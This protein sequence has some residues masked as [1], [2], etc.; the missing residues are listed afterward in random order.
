MRLL[1]AC[2]V[3][4][5]FAATA[6][7]AA[8]LTAT[9]RKSEVKLHAAPD[10]ESGVAEETEAGRHGRHRLAAGAL[11]RVE[12]PRR[13]ERLRAHQRCAG[14][15][16]QRRGQQRQH[17]RADQRQGGRG[18]RFRDRGG[19]RHRG[20]RAESGL[21]QPDAARHDGREPY[22]RHGRGRICRRARLAGDDRRLGRRGETE[23][24]RQEGVV[25]GSGRAA[26]PVRHDG[27]ARPEGELATRH[28]RQG[29]AEVRIRTGGGGNR[30]GP[31]DRRTR[32]WR[33][34]AVE[35][36]RGAEARQCGRPLGRLADQPPRTALDL[37]RDRH[38]GGQRL[39][40][41]RRLHP[42][43]TRP[44]R[45]ALLRR[46]ARR[47]ARPRDQPRGRARPLQRDPQAGDDDYRQGRRGRAR[48]MSAPASRRTTQNSTS[49]STARRSWSPRSTA[50][51]SSAPTRPRR[52][53][54][55]APG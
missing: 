28:R 12:A 44:V 11:V 17:A 39:R 25:V 34:P 3:A 14:E 42:R 20:K 22:R 26:G 49:S 29:R 52:S 13:L 6:A 53:T 1:S 18:A 55:R 43:D 50:R 47:R 9:V 10:L 5:L 27:I 54:S 36:S 38:R 8:D 24:G 19:A 16:R 45:A 40:R 2:L 46:G 30:A 51:R 41:A 4:A 21:F 15:L 37:R 33:A 31:A 7:E 23:E 35:R 48:S 32:A